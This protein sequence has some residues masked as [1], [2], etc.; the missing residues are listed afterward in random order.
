MSA[1]ADHPQNYGLGHERAKRLQPVGKERSGRGVS[2]GVK[3]PLV[4]GKTTEAYDIPFWLEVQARLHGVKKETWPALFA[5]W[6]RAPSRVEPCLLMS[7]GRSS[8][9][10][11]R[12]IVSPD[13]QDESW[14]EWLPQEANP[15]QNSTGISTIDSTQ[16]A[17]NTD[18]SLSRYL[19]SIG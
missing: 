13:V 9:N 12:F 19:D 17:D 3:L 2:W 16:V 7:F 5:F 11:T 1:A 8:P 14:H 15:Q 18:S 10:L 6:N 4:K